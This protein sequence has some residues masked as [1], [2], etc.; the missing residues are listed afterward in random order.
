MARSSSQHGALDSFDAP[1]LMFAV[2]LTPT[3][4]L[5][6]VV[7]AVGRPPAGAGALGGGHV[8]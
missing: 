8:T 7:E 6:E 2:G 1:Y 4:E 3:P 5:V